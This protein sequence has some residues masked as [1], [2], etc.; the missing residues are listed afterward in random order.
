[1]ALCDC[2]KPTSHK[3]MCVA[4]WK[5]RKANNGPAGMRAKAPETDP[6]RKAYGDLADDVLLLRKRGHLVA[7][8]KGQIRVDS[9]VLTDDQVR[10]RAR[11]V[12]ILGEKPIAEVAAPVVETKKAGSPAP[13]LAARVAEL[14]QQV[15]RLFD[16]VADAIKGRRETLVD[17]AKGLADLETTLRNAA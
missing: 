10:A 1:M 16:V 12:R 3:G 15:A 11:M 2:G 5:V 8:F 7:R 9:D 14:E 17:Q 6:V 13:D 4:R